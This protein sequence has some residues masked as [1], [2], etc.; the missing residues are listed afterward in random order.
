MSSLMPAL[1]CNSSPV[2]CEAVDAGDGVRNL[3][4]AFLGERNQLRQRFEAAA[5]NKPA[6]E[7]ASEKKPP[8]QAAR[9]KQ[10]AAKAPTK[11]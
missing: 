2:M 8:D 6:D 3:A 11:N 7:A 9:E 4:G 5:Q 1:S 10:P